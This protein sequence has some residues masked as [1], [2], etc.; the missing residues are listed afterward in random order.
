M[1]ENIISTEKVVSSVMPQ[2]LVNHD[3]SSLT[4]EGLATYLATVRAVLLVLAGNMAEHWSLLCEALVTEL[5]A[6]RSLSR[7]GAVVLVK[8]G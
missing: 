2:S 5:T 4:L 3:S 7:V 6:V 1:T 8:T